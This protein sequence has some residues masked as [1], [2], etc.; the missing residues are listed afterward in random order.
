MTQ[1]PP[2]DTKAHLVELLSAA[3][4]SVAP[5][6]PGASIVL[7]R[8]KQAQHGDYACNLALQLAKPLK[9]NAARYRRSS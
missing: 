6:Q 3:L 7:E 9:R 2:P 5:D 1:A 4:K 8:P